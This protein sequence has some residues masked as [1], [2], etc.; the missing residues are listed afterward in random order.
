MTSIS[1]EQPSYASVGQRV[2]ASVLDSIFYVFVYAASLGLG[3]ILMRT[4][5]GASETLAVVAFLLGL[6][7]PLLGWVIFVLYSAGKKGYTPG[8]K[9]MSIRLVD[10]TTGQPIG[11]WRV[12]LRNIIL[13]FIASASCGIAVIVLLVMAH[14]HPRRQGWHD[15]AVNSVVIPASAMN[16]PEPALAVAPTGVLQVSLPDSQTADLPTP[17]A[18]T[19]AP[20]SSDAQTNSAPTSTPTAAAAAAPSPAPAPSLIGPPPGL[21]SP[22]P[23]SVESTPATRDEPEPASEIDEFTRLAARNIPTNA[24]WTLTPEFGAE[25]AVQGPVLVGRD[26]DVSLSQGANAWAL[27]D[28]DKT[29]SKTHAFLGVDDD[30]MWVEDWNSTNGVLVRRDGQ[31]IE[32]DPG[33]RFTLESGDELYL[34]DFLLTVRKH[35]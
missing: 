3:F 7:V 10:A 34:G 16:R 20:V 8:K 23:V 30:A 11:V 24:Q 31:E 17:P 32:L 4:L 15:L 25:R 21:V 14:N 27:D 9:I 22:P 6:G 1:P 5:M 33:Q 13:S 26:P 2:M 29:V 18:S 28:P 19:T 12:L 35:G